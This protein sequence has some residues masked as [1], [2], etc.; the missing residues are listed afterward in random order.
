MRLRLTPQ[1]RGNHGQ[2]K[3]KCRCSPHN[4]TQ[5]DNVILQKTS[6]VARLKRYKSLIEN[7]L[8]NS[9]DKY[10]CSSCLSLYKPVS[11]NNIPVNPDCE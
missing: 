10:V 11:A 7:K 8:I 5:T 3:K 6:S 4:D 2:F 1:E 9:R